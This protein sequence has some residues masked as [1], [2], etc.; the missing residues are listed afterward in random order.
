MSSRLPSFKSSRRRGDVQPSSLTLLRVEKLEARD[1][2]ATLVGLTTTNALV[3]FDSATPATIQSTV[4]VT[5]LQPSEN[6][7]GIDY[8]STNGTLYGVGS[9]NRIYTIN[10]SSGVASAVG[11][12]P[13]TPAISGANLGLNFNP[14]VDK[15]R[16]V[17]NTG[18]NLRIN[19]DTGVVAATD[20]PL[21]YDAAT[22]DAVIGGTAP[23]PTI[24][25]V[26]YTKNAN[27]TTGATVTTLYG[28]DANLDILVT[29]GGPGDDTTSL[30][31]NTG[32]LYAVN[33][34][35]FDVTTNSG[36]DI[37]AGT[38]KAY[39]ASGT[40]L[41]SV[42]LTTG[43]GTSI[44]VVGTGQTLR[45]L[46][47][48]PAA[49]GAGTIQLSAS[50]NSFPASRGPLAITVTRTGGTSLPTTVTY[51]TTDGTAKAGVD[52]FPASGAISFAAG[53]AT[54]NIFLSLPGGN[55]VPGAAK[56]FTLT[57]SAPTNGAVLGTA[58]TTTITIP[59]VAAGTL[60][61]KFTLVGSDAGSVAT[62]K[63]YDS[64]SNKLIFTIT[65]F[66]ATFTGGVN[67]ATGDINGDGTDDIIVGTG[68]GGGPR[69]VVIDG[70]NQKILA[71]FF[72]Y[73]PT[74]RGG[75]NVAAGDVNGDGFMD[76]ITGS[77]NGGGP[78]VRVIDGAE[79]TQNN[80]PAV[81][82]DFFA[83]ESSFRGGVN[84]SA[85]E[86]NNDKFADVLAGAGTGG[87]PRIVMFDGK[88]LPTA[89][90]TPPSIQNFFAYDSSFRSGVLVSAGDVNGDGQMDI[91]AGAGPG[92]GPN[93][94]AFDGKSVT[95]LQNFFA[96]DSAF[97]GG[98]R[99]STK[100]VNQDGIDE[101]IT[102]NGPGIAPLVKV[103]ANGTELSNFAP[104]DAT[105][106][107][108]IFVG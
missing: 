10:T 22:Y 8:R 2:P 58:S 33:K 4:P 107:G 77:G 98:V 16:V 88:T 86:F 46:A 51:A 13:F 14:A 68:V 66:E 5:G 45:G 96:Y 23:A 100:D 30:S 27:P 101:I 29:Q 21:A 48:A 7:L 36:F 94:R 105:L 1:V 52:Y 65:P 56:T 84:V 44:G 108:G 18:Q 61:G 32:V 67:V 19:A 64:I 37:E 103:F 83:F 87:G 92:G 24:V 63:A 40:K 74:F 15:I 39:V 106:T 53:E 26:A 81:I 50:T 76:V 42:N 41:Y 3:T 89:G 99:V 31:P 73:E 47:I 79:L 62:V 6:L 35:G 72:T 91:V 49:A 55:A 17:T 38:D 34:L 102:G 57:L 93:V 12:G 28:I 75:V 70:T 80:N 9:T 69:V 54:K 59:A 104:F 60:S 71:D 95:Q 85:G 82:A 20:T 43:A 97:R 78:R 11:T 90:G 25:S